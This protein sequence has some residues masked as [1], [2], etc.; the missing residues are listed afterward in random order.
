MLA[1]GNYLNGESARGG[2]FG[3]RLDSL[4]KICDIKMK[5]N[6]TSLMLYVVEKMEEKHKVNKFISSE[7]EEALNLFEAL[8]IS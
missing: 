6:K 8:P 7:D 3:F 1:V 5:D 4:I 2:A